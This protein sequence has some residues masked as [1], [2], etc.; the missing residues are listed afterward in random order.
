MP[1][2]QALINWSQKTFSDLPWRHN[3]S[4]YRTWVSEVML[5]QTTVATVS[6]RFEEFLQRFPDI[7]A[8]A[9][10]SEEDVLSAWRGLGYYR[11]AVN[12]H[13]GARYLVEHH[14][15]R[16]PESESALMNIPGIGEYTAAAL[17]AIG[18]NRP[19]LPLDA[20]LKRV[21]A[22][23]LAI[24]PDRLKKELREQF[25]RGSLF[26][27]MASL[28]PR[29]LIE[30]LMDLGRV[31]C[32]ANSAQCE[33]CPLATHCL[34]HQENTPLLYGRP[35]KSAP[36]ALS[37]KLLRVVVRQEGKVLAYPKREGEWLTGQWELPTF[38]LHSE[39]EQLS[40]YPS[41]K[42]PHPPLTSLP[43][44]TTHIT[45]YRIRKPYSLLPTGIL[46]QNLPLP[47][48]MGVLQSP[49]ASLLTLQHH[50]QNT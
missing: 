39:D 32:R 42:V 34:A 45:R 35:M 3:R 8:L 50:T 10:G 30:A 24:E 48:G 28:G 36:A 1:P 20:N 14:Q 44:I 41:L 4:L 21:M 9:T 19:A 17:T 2:F 25:S 49:P 16:L 6:A 27:N 11:R 13:K 38:I 33:E 43:R 12:L 40:Q 23:Y 7:H 18:R 46:S 26:P 47:S 22:R 31:H 29:K 5:Q 37:L 15:G